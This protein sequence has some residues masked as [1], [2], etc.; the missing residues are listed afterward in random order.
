VD[1]LDRFRREVSSF[2]RFCRPEKEQ[3]R[4]AF[5]V[6]EPGLQA[7]GQ[8]KALDTSGDARAAAQRGQ[9][10]PPSPKAGT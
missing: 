3:R 9:M 5:F 6:E 10:K 4:V 7:G 8:A 2:S 1:Y